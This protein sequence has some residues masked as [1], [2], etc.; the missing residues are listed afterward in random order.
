MLT[1]QPAR[2]NMINSQD[3]GFL[4]AIL[5]GVVVPP[6]NFPFGQVDLQPGAFDHIAK[7]YYRWN[8]IFV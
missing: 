1:T 2:D 6:Q 7:L 4:A 8:F 3:A 5:A